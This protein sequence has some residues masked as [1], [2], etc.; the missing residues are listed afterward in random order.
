MTQIKKK[1]DIL[2]ISFNHSKI[3]AKKPKGKPWQDESVSLSES[4]GP[5]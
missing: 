2:H 3:N 5:Q 1:K 4:I